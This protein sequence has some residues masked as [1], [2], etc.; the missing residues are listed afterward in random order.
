MEYKNLLRAFKEHFDTVDQDLIVK[1]SGELKGS[2][3]QSPDDTEA[4][5]RKKKKEGSK[6]YVMNITESCDPDNKLQ[7][8]TSCSVEANAV[9]DQKLLKDDIE[10]LTER[11]AV[12][13]LLTDGGYAGDIAS[14]CTQA[15]KIEHHVSGIRGRERAKGKLGLE[16]FTLSRNETGNVCKVNCPSGYIGSIRERRKENCYIVAFDNE[17]CHN[18]PFVASCPTKKRKR[19]DLRVLRFCD[20]DVRIAAQRQQL[21]KDKASGYLNQRASIESTVRSVIHPFGGHLCK[22]SVRGRNRITTMAVLSSAMVNIRR[23]RGYLCPERVA[24]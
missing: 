3:L 24:A 9:D 8:I 2:N 17:K 15:N 18:C 13:E 14:E 12:D 4:T 10:N 7:L 16:D 11:M 5:Y 1:K 22:L 23:I 20:K 21:A 19:K 6:G